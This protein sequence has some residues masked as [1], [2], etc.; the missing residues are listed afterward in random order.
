MS[1]T[2]T[3]LKQKVGDFVIQ[4]YDE[5]GG[6]RSSPV[7]YP[8]F[9][10]TY[11]A[12]WILKNF[13]LDFAAGDRCIGWLVNTKTNDLFQTYY[14]VGSLELLGSYDLAKIKV[15]ES[16]N[17][18]EGKVRFLPVKK[19]YQIEQE[20]KKIYAFGEL[21]SRISKNMDETLLYE[22]SKYRNDDGGYGKV[23]HSTITS[24][25]Y[26]LGAHKVSH[27]MNL[28][29][30]KG[31]LSFIRSL[32]RPE[33]GFVTRPENILPYMEYTY[34]GIEALETLGESVNFP[35]E[36]LRFV[37]NCLNKDGGFR[38][39]PILGI[40]GIENVF[41]A[42]SILTKLDIGRFLPYAF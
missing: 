40:S 10:S 23:N 6:F 34:Y 38:R 25:Y 11:H 24:T 36:H 20:F 17:I 32:E 35:E 39:T 14:A 7:D 12:L 1:L 8:N 21:L 29:D 37:L 19:V 5:S 30:K 33:G 27:R 9:A 13:D 31:V 2:L 28:I 4:R 16:S 22:L 3:S 26:V 42:T 15:L 41:Y 18:K